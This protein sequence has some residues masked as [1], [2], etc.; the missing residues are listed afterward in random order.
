M[1]FL[2]RW[3]LWWFPH[4]LGTAAMTSDLVWSWSDLIIIWSCV[5]HH[6]PMPHFLSGLPF[7]HF[8]S[9]GILLSVALQELRNH[10]A[11]PTSLQRCHCYPNHS[12]DWGVLCHGQWM[13][14]WTVHVPN[15]DCPAL[16][17]F[18]WQRHISNASQHPSLHSHGTIQ[19][20]LLHEAEGVYQEAVW[21]FG[22][23]Y[24]S[25]LLYM[26]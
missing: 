19:Q 6:P 24:W 5:H 25:S 15:E 1:S 23:C 22:C 14:L 10:T 4:S 11:V 12:L 13:A 7:Q 3:S 21:E 8:Q 17:T 26:L 20:N 18:L 2:T 9:L 16:C